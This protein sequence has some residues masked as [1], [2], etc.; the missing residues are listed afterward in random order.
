ML[1]PITAVLDLLGMAAGLWLAVYVLARGYRSPITQRAFIVLLCLALFFYGAYN[2]IF[3]QVPGTAAWRAVALITALY[4]WYDLTN[5]L[6]PG[7]LRRRTRFLS[8]V[9]LGLAA[10]AAVLLLTVPNAFR[11]EVGNALNIGRM[12]LELPFIAYGL[13]MIVVSIGI[14]NNHRLTRTAGTSRIHRYFYTASLIAVINVG[15][16]IL[17]LAILEP[18]SRIIQDGLILASVIVLGYSVAR[19]QTFVEQ[20]TTFM[21]FQVSSLAVMALTAL[22]GLAGLLLDYSPREIGIIVGLAVLSL[23]SYDFVRTAI[24]DVL[25]REECQL[26]R[27]LLRIARDSAGGRVPSSQAWI[28]RSLNILL[29]TIQ[30]EQGL[31]AMPENGEFRVVASRQSLPGGSPLPPDLQLQGDLFPLAGANETGLAW[32]APCTWQGRPLAL[33]AVGA[34]EARAY[35]E[36]D[37]DVL[38]EFADQVALLLHLESLQSD[39]THR[40]ARLADD[41]Q[42]NLLSLQTG[43]EQ[44]V[45]NLS[46]QPAPE[47]VKS[48]E[49]GLRKLADVSYLGRSP[50]AGLLGVPGKTH[51]ERG[52]GV[53]DRLLA[54]LETLRPPEKRPPE[55]LPRE[56][57]SYVILHD[58]YVQ[59]V[60]NRE[61][62]ARLYISEGTFNRTRRK[63]IR[64]L[65]RAIREM[66]SS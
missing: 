61:I 43:G 10:T 56:W 51:L 42:T 47:L 58:A 37:L 3:E 59:D 65:A 25:A 14:L 55:P 15:H 46:R 2:N 40:L 29:E 34:R 19:H 49:E 50:L 32:I 44:I 53:R 6:L 16:G 22:F 13:F 41:Y 35:S 52:Q 27:Q 63:A 38:V 48:V 66:G 12:E 11:G 20:R 64:A 4:F 60:P 7:N 57:H 36:S 33:V 5:R 28:E 54:L 26:R 1:I 8:W 21:D 23:S 45:E 30:A 31:I 17:S 39:Q 62:M 18:Q 24:N 9:T